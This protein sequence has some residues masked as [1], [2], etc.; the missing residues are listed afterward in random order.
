MKDRA[1]SFYHE[2]V[3]FCRF[4]DSLNVIETLD[5][6]K[7]VLDK[8]LYL[9]RQGLKLP[10]VEPDSSDYVIA[11]GIP[12]PNVKIRDDDAYWEIFDAYT[13]EEPVQGSLTD[14]VSDIYHDLREGIALYE[15]KKYN[16]AVWSWRFNFETHWGSHAIDAARALHYLIN[17][18]N[19]IF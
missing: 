9:Y 1:R 11:D 14:D 15:E 2:A 13:L 17:K 12:Y 8:L 5:E 18:K 10:Q 4:I 3:L 16:E 7:R 19:E 6:Y